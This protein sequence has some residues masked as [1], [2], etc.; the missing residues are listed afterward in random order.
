MYL[1]NKT[2]VF[3]W[4]QGQE[5]LPGYIL[6]LLDLHSPIP[7]LQVI[8]E[9]WAELPVLYNSFPLAI[10]FTH[11]NYT[12]VN[13]SLPSHPTLLQVYLSILYV[14]IP[15]LQIVSFV[16]SFR[17]HIYALI[18]DSFFLSFWFT[19]LCMTDS[20][21]IHVSI[22]DTVIFKWDFFPVFNVRAVHVSRG[23]W[24]A[25]ETNQC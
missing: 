3:Q 10:Y 7:S 6:S 20:R 21:S 15:A 4:I 18:Y 14:S 5:V 19:S 12:H 22:N 23:G 2:V 17:F 24:L 1:C 25:F 9:H 8:T 11:G 13:P 16:P